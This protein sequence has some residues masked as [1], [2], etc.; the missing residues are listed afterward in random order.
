MNKLEH[1]GYFGSVEYSAEDE[2]LHGRLLNIHDIVTY[3]GQSVD[4]LKAHFV[5]SVEGYLQMCA[6]LGKAPDKPVSG[7]FNVRIPPELHRAAQRAAAE[8]DTSLNEVVAQA[9]ARYLGEHAA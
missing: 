2:V 9:L 3:E 7:K 6:E 8:Q 5:E 1:Q 4:E